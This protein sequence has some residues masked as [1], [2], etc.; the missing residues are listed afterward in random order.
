ML[1]ATENQLTI[2]AESFGELLREHKGQDVSVMDLRQMSNWTD[3]FVIATVSSKTH[4]DGIERHVKEFCREQDIEILGHSGFKK[5]GF[6]NLEQSSGDE[7]RLIDL[8]WGVIHLMN[9]QAR[10]FYELE[11]LWYSHSTISD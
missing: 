7:W 11:R 9:K 3:F 2:L 5:R 4:M 10:D 1:P 6:K 8:G